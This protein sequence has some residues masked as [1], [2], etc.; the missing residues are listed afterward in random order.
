MLAGW[1]FGLFLIPSLPRSSCEKILHIKFVLCLLLEI[2]CPMTIS[3]GQLSGT[4]ANN[5]GAS[6]DQFSCNQGY[7]KNEAVASLI[8]SQSGTW[9]YNISVS[10]AGVTKGKLMLTF[11]TFW[12]Y[13]V[14]EKLM[15]CVSFFPE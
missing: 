9:S 12:A 4:C 10:C 13:S 3:N 15:I 8:C 7:E 1:L 2:Q 14:D 5:V 11:S 6:C